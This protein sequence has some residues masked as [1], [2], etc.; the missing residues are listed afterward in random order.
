[1]VPNAL[2]D[3]SPRSAVFEVR[4]AALALGATLGARLARCPGAA[5]FVDFGR[6]RS[7]AKASLCAVSRHRPADPLAAPGSADLS[8]EVDFAAFAEAAEAAGA[9]ASGPVPQNKFLQALGAAERLAVLSA[10]AS[11]SQRERLE[12]G[13]SR[14]LDPQQMGALFKAMAL[15]SPELSTPPGFDDWGA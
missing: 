7:A 3:T 6:S 5:L 15:T 9:E 11:P 13:M 1:L 14:L 12:S 10:H 8:A 2:R 4:P